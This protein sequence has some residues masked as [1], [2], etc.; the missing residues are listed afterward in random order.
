MAAPDL[1][2]ARCPRGIGQAAD[3]SG[4]VSDRLGR[5]VKQVPVGGAAVAG[6][7]PRARLPKV[8]IARSLDHPDPRQRD[9]QRHKAEN[10]QGDRA[11]YRVFEVIA[12]ALGLDIAGRSDWA[13]VI[14]VGRWPPGSD[15]TSRIPPGQAASQSA[16][17][18]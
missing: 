16:D 8:S 10:D 18:P 1:E 3:A 6:R 5:S 9:Q 4:G 15:Q 2:A 11:P 17:P 7:R 12:A 13:L 14:S